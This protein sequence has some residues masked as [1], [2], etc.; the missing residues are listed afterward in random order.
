MTEH[1][2]DMNITK[3]EKYKEKTEQRFCRG[4]KN[5]HE[6]YW[7]T[8]QHFYEGTLNRTQLHFGES[9]NKHIQIQQRS[10]KP[11]IPSQK[12]LTKIFN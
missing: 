7:K 4:I 2:T 11:Q 12:R 8:E 3:I 6:P 9:N 10:N 5:W 1:K